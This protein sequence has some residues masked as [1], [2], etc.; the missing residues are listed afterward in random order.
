MQRLKR[1]TTKSF[2]QQPGGN[3]NLDI[4]HTKRTTIGKKNNYIINCIKYTPKNF[5]NSF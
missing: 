4:T 2:P 3:Q 1:I 5:I